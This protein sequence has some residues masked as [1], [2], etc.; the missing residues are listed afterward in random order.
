M[1]IASLLT[2]SKWSIVKELTKGAISPTELAK[3]THTSIANISQQLK[4][5]E[6]YGL[7][8]REKVLNGDNQPGKPKSYYKLTKDIIEMTFIT[9][10][11]AV[12][13]S[14]EPNYFMKAIITSCIQLKG[15]DCFL[16]QKFMF[17]N[18]EVIQKCEAIGVVKISNESI[19]LL[20]ITNHI[21]EI[22]QKYINQTLKTLEGKEKKIVCWTHNMQELEQGIKTKE[23]HFM[24]LT[25]N[26]KELM[27]K[28]DTFKKIEAMRNG[29]DK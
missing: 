2:D 1:E 11:L 28:N 25:D 17:I 6:A 13:K 9:K 8:K 14:M 27:D 4:L 21:D 23:Q 5:L 15:D 19:D 22:R 12:R 26:L 16:L 10:N 7:V 24:F 29:E 20:L 3:K 18:E